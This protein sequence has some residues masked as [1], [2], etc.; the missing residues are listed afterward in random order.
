MLK[1]LAVTSN[2]SF[3]EKNVY[4][5]PLSIIIAGALIGGGLWVGLRNLG[6]VGSGDSTSTGEGTAGNEKPQSV[7]MRPV[8]S[9]DHI[10][11]DAKA[12][13]TLVEYSD[14][15]CPFC[16]RFHPTMQQVMKEY[17]G[18]VRWVYR[19]FPLAQLH[20]K[21]QKE[22]EASECAA[23]Q[24]K[25]W[26]FVDRLFEITPSNNGLDPAELPKIAQYIN[27]DVNKFSTCLS[28]GQYTKKVEADIQ[29]AI[30]AG[31]QGTPYS[32]LI[33]AKGEKTPISGALP[34]ENI[35]AV[36]DSKL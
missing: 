20:P 12:S 9:G 15:E 1:K 29:D 27:I 18:K 11:G 23:G 24:G 26:E 30:N 35:K 3:M 5:V 25:F 28:S 31:A 33:D 4:L 16:K 36:I 19:H 32:V 7:S 21:A 2:L 22:A 14:L 34:Y 8:G 6:S 13:L 17:P 10:R